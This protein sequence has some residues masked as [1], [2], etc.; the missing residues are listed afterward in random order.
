LLVAME[1]GST[2]TADLPAADRAFLYVMSGRLLAGAE[3]EELAAGTV[4]W[5]DPA[6]PTGRSRTAPLTLKA[7]DGDQVTRAMLFSGKPIREP[8]YASGP[9]V[10]TCHE[11]IEQAF[12]DYRAGA[13]GAVP[14]LARR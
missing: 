9:F 12:T 3:S 4:G 5:S 8:V 7:P 6:P 10:M 14:D 11:E 13:F 2:W 1:P